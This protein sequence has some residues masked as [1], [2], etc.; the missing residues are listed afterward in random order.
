[1]I[2]F[3]TSSPTGPLDGSRV[4]DGFDKMNQFSVNVKARWKENAKCLMITAF[5]EDDAANDEML[6]F[7]KKTLQK[8]DL[9]FQTFDIWDGRTSD[10]S[11]EILQSY[12]VIF[13]GGGHVPTQNTFFQKIQLREKLEGFDGMLIGISAGTMNSADIVYA[14]PELPGESI[15]P[16]Y[17]RCIRGL[18]LTN[19]NILP[20]YQMVKDY[21]LDGVRLYEDI[22]YK[23][24]MGKQFF[25]LVDGSYLLQENGKEKIYGEAYLIANGRIM[26]ICEENEI[27]SL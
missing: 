15:D 19:V 24:S 9:S 5:P 4:V 1:M 11:G 10:Y 21:M 3:L 12:D 27:C 2:L 13:L 22:I 16:D 18:G 26:K 17:A 20:H 6:D 25:V 8:E 7:F 14:Q 23:D